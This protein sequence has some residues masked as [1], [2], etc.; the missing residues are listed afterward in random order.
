[1]ERRL[2]SYI[3]CLLGL[4]AGD[5]M[6]Y[7]VDGKT[8]A[9]IRNDYGPDGL[10][11]YDLVNGYADI[12][13]YTQLAAFVCNGLLLGMTRG[14][15]TG[16]MQPFVRYIA[17]GE[18]DW[19]RTQK[20]RR[21]PNERIYCWVAKSDSL[22]A[23][24]C[25]DTLML[26][27]LNRGRLGTM[28]EQKNRFQTPGSITAA[29]PVG[30][31]FDPDHSSREE[32]QRLGAEAVAITH[33]N[34]LAFLAGAALAHIISRLSWDGQTRLKPVVQE[35]VQMLRERFSAEYR[36]AEDVC[37]DLERALELAGAHD[38]GQA[39]AME[40]LECDTASK[41]LAGAVYACLC[42]P[43]NFDEAMI[44][45][46]NHSGY[47]AAV[48]AV[49]GAILGA[50]LGIGGLPE[51]YLECLEPAQVLAELARDMFQGCPMSGVSG[52]FDIEWDD[53]YISF[54][55]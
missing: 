49:A 55:I 42:H 15:M 16:A 17:V 47:S 4:A 6:G 20:Y 39:D 30:L 35:A 22:R 8:L 1:M 21:E 23:R 12:S 11:G 44:T 31:F 53:K 43:T 25:M 37:R 13:S 24:R 36:Q 14:Q 5:A 48:G 54:G 2:S 50:C 19:S 40:Q 26:D 38:I 45:A 18:R 27:T 10:L 34:P 32:I 3:G 52:M 9:Q 28:E 51:F 33:G 29:V 41:A 7:A 46:V